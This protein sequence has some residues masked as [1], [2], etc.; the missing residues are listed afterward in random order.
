IPFP[1]YISPKLS[2]VSNPINEMGK[3]AARWVLQQVY[4]DQEMT[5]DSSFKPE[6]FIRTS[7]KQID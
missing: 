2:T 3:M 1:Q 7:A 4:N 6:L 5:V